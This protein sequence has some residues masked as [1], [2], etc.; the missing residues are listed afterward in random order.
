MSG[1]AAG[2]G[3][4]S[5]VNYSALVDTII[6]SQSGVVDRLNS[7]ITGYQSTSTGLSQLEATVLA[8]NTSVQQLGNDSTF[9]AF[10][11]NNSDEAQLSVK[12]TA[13]AV[14]GTYAFQAVQKA[15]TN[16]VLSKGFANTDSQKLDT[17]HDHDCH[18][19]AI[20][21]RYSAGWAESRRRHFAGQNSNHR[22]FRAVRDSEFDQS[23]L[24]EDVPRCHQQHRQLGCSGHGERRQPRADRYLRGHRR[25]SFGGDLNGGH[26]ALDLGIDQ[27]IGANTLT[28]RTCIPSSGGYALSQ[29]NDGNALEPAA[30]KTDLR[31]TLTDDS[32]LE[33]NLDGAN[34]LDDVVGLINNDDNNAGRVSACLVNGQAPIARF[35]RR[36]GK[37]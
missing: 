13:D 18:R 5:G 36:R 23:L 37:Q 1:L 11:I 25:Q 12:T 3:L 27:S 19:R 9:N 35:D 16:Q 21:F 4:I 7:R 32:T 15:A 24:G 30:D 17:G 10:Q 34:T 33:I 2:V 29:I 8:I 31:I 14:S 28:G 6:K 22:P 20:E 26:T